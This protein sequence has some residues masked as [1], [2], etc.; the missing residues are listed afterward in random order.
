MNFFV[1]FVSRCIRRVALSPA[2]HTGIIYWIITGLGCC[3]W[4][5][6]AAQIPAAAL[7]QPKPPFAYA[8]EEVRFRN[9]TAQIRLAGTFTRPRPDGR[10]PAVITITGSGPQDRNESRPHHKPFWVIADYLSNHGIAVL[11]FD[12]RG[13]GGSTGKYDK[14]DIFD[15]ATDVQAAIQYLRSRPD[16]DTTAIGLLGHSEGAEV[17][18]IVAASYPGVAF[19][20]SA[21][22]PGLK[23]ADISL[24]QQGVLAGMMEMDSAS[25]TREIRSNAAFF[26]ILVKERNKDTM[27]AKAA[28]FLSAKYQSLQPEERGH[29]SEAKYVRSLLKVQTKPEALSVLRFDPQ[30]YLPHI[31]CPFLAISGSKDLQ[32]DASAN[33]KAIAEGLATGGNRNVTIKAFEGLNH[34]LQ[35]CNTCK[36]EEYITLPQTIAPPVLALL[37]NWIQE[38]VNH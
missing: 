32:L 2:A 10:Y 34:L 35:E 6:A 23:G 36:P 14:A 3:A 18:Q 8:V 17:A 9:A 4:A 1:R 24:S 20:I 12:D 19:V 5:M 25:A 38:V 29:E 7:Q 28:A 27:L 16:V 13:V 37:A 31:H 33:L 21:S 26:D 30:L 22:G 15:F 11:R